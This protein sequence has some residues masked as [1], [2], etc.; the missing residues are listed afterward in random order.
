MVSYSNIKEKLE[1]EYGDLKNTLNDMTVKAKQITAKKKR[2]KAPKYEP[3]SFVMPDSNKWIQ[4]ILG[5]LRL[6]LEANMKSEIDSKLKAILNWSAGIDQYKEE[7]KSSSVYSIP[8]EIYGKEFELC[9]IPTQT[10]K[11]SEGSAKESSQTSKSCNCLSEG[12]SFIF[13]V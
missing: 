11:K 10:L 5:L 2:S 3:L 13:F 7:T 9:K 6:M 1:E 8:D 4:S 12:R